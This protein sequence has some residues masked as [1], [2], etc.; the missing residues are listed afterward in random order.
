MMKNCHHSVLSAA[1]Q[2]ESYVLC[3]DDKRVFLLKKNF[4]KLQKKNPKNRETAA[5]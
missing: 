4:L 3:Q 2:N 5:L 1:L